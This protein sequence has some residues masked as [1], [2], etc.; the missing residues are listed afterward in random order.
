MNM[1]LIIYCYLFINIQLSNFKIL[2]I[3]I[4]VF[5]YVVQ[6]TP[7]SINDNLKMI[8]NVK[9]GFTWKKCILWDQI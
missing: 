7:I 5:H 2:K 3:L 8:I 4:K 6:Y 9:N 1:I